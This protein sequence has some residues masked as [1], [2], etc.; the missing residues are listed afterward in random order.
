MALGNGTGVTEHM[1]KLGLQISTGLLATIPVVTG[2]IGLTGL[3]DPVYAST[4]LP[5]NANAR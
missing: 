1:S 3:R 5:T 4:G 2:L